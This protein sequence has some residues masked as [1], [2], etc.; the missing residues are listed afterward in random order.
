MKRL[1]KFVFTSGYNATSLQYY[2]DVLV[3]SIQD[4]QYFL[5]KK[6]A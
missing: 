1:G 3:Q 4:L 5:L 6:Y 2:T